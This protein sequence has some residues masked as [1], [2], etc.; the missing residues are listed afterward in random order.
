MNL[1]KD[2][3]NKLAD[4][5]IAERDIKN[6]IDEIYPEIIASLVDVED[7]AMIETEKGSFTVS[8]RR[9]WEYPEVIEQRELELKKEKKI[10]EQ[11]GVATYT[12]KPSVIFKEMVQ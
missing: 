6:K 9:T 7:G 8:Q 3:F 4:L 2:L 12:V 10:A 1:N 11:M 5:R